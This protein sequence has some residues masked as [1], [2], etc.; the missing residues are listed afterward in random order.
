MHPSV[1]CCSDWWWASV[2]RVWRCQECHNTSPHPSN[3]ETLSASQI[4]GESHTEWLMMICGEGGG[5]RQKLDDGGTNR[6]RVTSFLPI[7]HSQ[8]PP[9][10]L[11]LGK[12]S[13]HSKS[14]ETRYITMHK[15]NDCPFIFKELCQAWPRTG[16]VNITPTPAMPSGGLRVKLSTLGEEAPTVRKI[17]PISSRRSLQNQS[18]KVYKTLPHQFS[19]TRTRWRGWR[20]PGTLSGTWWGSATSGTVM[21]TPSQTANLMTSGDLLKRINHQYDE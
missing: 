3:I 14:F 21:T 12:C 10:T 2:L 4:D 16:S 18:L 8:V 17:G 19:A 20:R 9:H 11:I 6:Y 13:F 5:K 15:T 1:E 7:V